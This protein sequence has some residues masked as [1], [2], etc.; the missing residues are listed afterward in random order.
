VD[1]VAEITEATGASF[2]LWPEDADDRRDGA[3]RRRKG[4]RIIARARGHRDK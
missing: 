2:H 1:E 4:G 3:G